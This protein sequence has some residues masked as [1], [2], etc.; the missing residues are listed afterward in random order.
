MVFKQT[1]YLIMVSGM[2][3]GTT[4]S[5]E[6]KVTI[7]AEEQPLGEVLDDIQNASG[8][9][10]VLSDKKWA[11]EPVSFSVRHSDLEQTLDAALGGYDYVLEWR[12]DNGAIS[13]VLVTV[14]EEKEGLVNVA[15]KVAESRRSPER[16]NKKG[17]NDYA[18]AYHQSVEKK[19]V[20]YPKGM[21]QKDIQAMRESMAKLA[22][23]LK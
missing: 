9:D 20:V 21:T 8:V 2:L 1:V 19:Q 7:S 18:D 15:G 22:G 10:V 12:A 11:S 4:C 5:A 6:P 3:A 23:N 17:L 14:H 16:L 13:S